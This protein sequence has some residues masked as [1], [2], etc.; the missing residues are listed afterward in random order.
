MGTPK[1]TPKCP[2]ETAPEAAATPAAPAAARPGSWSIVRAGPGS[3]DTEGDLR[4]AP[5]WPPEAPTGR[6]DQRGRGT[7]T[8]IPGEARL[9][10]GRGAEPPSLPRPGGVATERHRPTCTE[11][12]HRV[13]W[14]SAA[15]EPGGDPTHRFLSW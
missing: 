8:P 15:R 11:R 7:Q 14:P 12:E 13:T 9:E 6:P 10:S 5:Y 4:N 1:G 2:A 3:S